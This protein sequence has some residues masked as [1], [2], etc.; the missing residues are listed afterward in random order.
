MPVYDYMCD[1]CGPFT[2]MRPMSEYEDPH[3]CP[4]CGGTSPRALLTAPNFS[5]VSGDRRAI[6]GVNERAQ[7]APKSVAEFKAQRHGAGCSCCGG[8]AGRGRTAVRGKSGAKT[9]PTARPWMI[10]H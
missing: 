4:D 8:G 9:F 10:S 3:A 6:H 1:A 7:S 5:C 2:A